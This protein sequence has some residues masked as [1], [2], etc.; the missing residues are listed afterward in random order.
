MKSKFK[1]HKAWLKVSTTIKEQIHIRVDMLLLIVFCNFVII[2]FKPLAFFTDIG[3][4][5]STFTD[6]IMSYYT[7]KQVSNA[8]NIKILRVGNGIFEFNN[9]IIFLVSKAIYV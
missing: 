6:S 5:V 2:T 4:V 9:L 1:G 8:H 3:N 7:I